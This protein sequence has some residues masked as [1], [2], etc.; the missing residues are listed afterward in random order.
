[1]IIPI[2]LARLQVP[3]ATPALD[4][5]TRVDA[6]LRQGLPHPVPLT[7]N[8]RLLLIA[9]SGVA[10]L[11]RDLDAS[12][13]VADSADQQLAASAASGSVAIPKQIPLRLL[14]Q[15]GN[16]TAIAAPLV[17]GGTQYL[18]DAG[19]I[20]YEIVCIDWQL[21]AGTL[22]GAGDFGSRLSIAWRAADRALAHF[23]DPPQN[24][25]YV[26]RQ[27]PDRRLESVLGL[28][29]LALNDRFQFKKTFV[30]LR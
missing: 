10:A 28:R 23:S 1:M 11:W 24:P 2:G 4:G 7:G 22:R 18:S 12:T 17:V 29:R 15:F 6:I 19:A 16:R 8:Q 14:L 5:F 25:V 13:I 30:V 9:P 21:H 27:P 3:D 26:K 20:R